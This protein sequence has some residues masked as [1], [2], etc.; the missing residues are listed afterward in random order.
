IPLQKNGKHQET[1]IP[2]FEKTPKAK[3]YPAKLHSPHHNNV[4]ENQASVC[5]DGRLEYKRHVKKSE[6]IESDS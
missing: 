4:G 1:R 2:C 6:A 3:K 5:R